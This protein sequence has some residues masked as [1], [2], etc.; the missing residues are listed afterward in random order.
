MTDTLRKRLGANIDA[1]TRLTTQRYAMVDRVR[2]LPWLQK[3]FEAVL[4]DLIFR[5][6][7]VSHARLW[8]RHHTAMDEARRAGWSDQEI[9]KAI[10]DGWS[11]KSLDKFRAA[12]LLDYREGLVG[13][14]PSLNG[15]DRR[16][17]R[18]AKAFVQSLQD[19]A[20]IDP[21]AVRPS[22]QELL[23]DITKGGHHAES[24]ETIRPLE[25]DH[26]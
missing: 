10:V 3:T 2:N 25:T 19:A 18:V 9:H 21:Y 16:D 6:M 4:N 23:D 7:N 13:E 20:G 24:S 14:P 12:Y 5:S 26:D 22:L 1:I 11:P 8:K 15:L 17:S